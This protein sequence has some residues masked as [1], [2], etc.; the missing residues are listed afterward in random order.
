MT[1]NLSYVGLSATGGGYW[2]LNGVPSVS[3]T[4]GS[5]SDTFNVSAYVGAASLA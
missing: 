5:A 4:G 2:S 1:F 3:L